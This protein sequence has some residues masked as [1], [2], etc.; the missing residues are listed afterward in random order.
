MWSMSEFCFTD[1][2]DFYIKPY[3]MSI[4]DLN[5]YRQKFD[6]LIKTQIQEKLN[7]RKLCQN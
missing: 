1:N 5:L 2:K 6:K 3:N 4:D 7:R